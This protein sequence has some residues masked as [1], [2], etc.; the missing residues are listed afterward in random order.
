MYNTLTRGQNAFGFFTTVAF[1]VAAFIAASDLLSPRAPGA[2]KLGVSSTQVYVY[3][4]EIIYCHVLIVFH[5][6]VLRADRTTT[7]LRRRS[8]PSFDS[9]WKPT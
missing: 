5:P 4:P 8:T 7:V 9:T 1:V 2:G 6:A 3:L